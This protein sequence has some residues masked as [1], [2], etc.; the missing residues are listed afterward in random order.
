M[1]FS[2]AETNKAPVIVI[3]DQ[4]PNSIKNWHKTSIHFAQSGYN[5]LVAGSWDFSL[6]S[7]ATLQ[8]R[9][10]PLFSHAIGLFVSAVI[11]VEASG[12]IATKLSVTDSTVKAL[13]TLDAAA[14]FSNNISKDFSAIP[15]RPYLMIETTSNPQNPDKLKQKI[16]EKAGD[17]KKAVW[18]ATNLT[19]SNILNSDME[20]IVRRTVLLLIDRY[21]KGKM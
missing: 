21:L 10:S 6:D 20:P 9:I 1:S 17:P 7:M 4:N 12:D 5:V 3:L 13:I 19:G 16:F 2:T 18:L 14:H 15:P 11:G 8:Q